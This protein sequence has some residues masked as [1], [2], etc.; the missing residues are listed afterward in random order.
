MHG[1]NAERRYPAKSLHAK[2]LFTHTVFGVSM[3]RDLP[4]FKPV[5]QAELRHIWVA[6]PE[7]RRLVLEVERYRRVIAEIDGLYKVPTS[8]G[9]II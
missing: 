1:R 9:G 6:H 8:R 4:P 2:I 3:A 7:F 5:T